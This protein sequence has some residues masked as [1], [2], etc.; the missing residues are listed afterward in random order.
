[1]TDR[2]P[3]HS[4]AA[5]RVL[6]PDVPVVVAD[7]TTAAVLESGGEISVQPAAKLGR[8]MAAARP[9]VC[10][11]PAVA[12]R[13]KV[14]H[15]AAFDVLE[16]FAFVRPAAF[17][18]PT[19]AGLTEALGLPHP[20]TLEDRPL[21]LR[22]VVKT[23]LGELTRYHDIE[24]KPLAE[25]AS[26]MARG[27]WPWGASVLAALGGDPHAATGYGPAAGL[28]VWMRLP[29]WEERPPPP[30]PGSYPIPP[31]D[32]EERLERLLGPGAEARPAQRAYTRAVTAAFQPRPAPEQ[33]LLVLAEAGTG[34]GK[35]LGYVAPASL[36]AERND[37]AVWLSTFTRNLQRQLDQELDRLYPDPDEKKRKV[38]IRKGRENY[39]CILNY[40]D[41]VNRLQTQP[42]DATA[43]GLL[44]RWAGATRNGD[45]VGGDL[46]GWLPE[47]IGREKTL[48]MADRRGECIYAACPHY[49][50]CFIERTV[51][52]ARHANI[53]VANH[54]LV[55]AQAA[56]GGLDDTVRPTRY[57]FDEGHHIFEAADSAFSAQL[58]GMEA[59]DLRRWLLGAEGNAVRTRARGLKRRAEDLIA[60]G[61]NSGASND[62]GL[63]IALDETLTGARALPGQGWRNRVKD[64]VPH[65]PTEIFLGL[66]RKQVLARV[67]SSSPY[68]L[69]A[70]TAPLIEGLADA[71]KDLDTALARLEQP[72]RRLMSGFQRKLDTEA[73]ELDTASR[74]R[75][76]AL[77]RT[78]ERRGAIPA[79]AWRSMLGA[80]GAATPAEF[81]DW[82]SIERMDGQDVDVG[83]HRHWVDPTLPFARALADHTHGM[84][85]TSAT[86]L[87]GEEDEAA[88]WSNAE[89]RVGALHLAPPVVRTAL[90]SPFNY[91]ENT[92]VIVITD[93]RK[94]DLSQVAAAYR[95][96]FLAS[97]G[98]ALGLF[99]AIAR[100]R[101]VHR[102]ISGA[103]DEAGL[104][105]YAQHVDAMDIS[106]L[107]DIFRA[108]EDACLL[109]TDAVREGVD[110]PGRSLRLV[111]FDRVP[112]PRPDIL[113]KARRTAFGKRGYDDAVTRL[114]LKQAF[115]RLIRRDTDRGV[116]VLLDPM[117]PSRLKGA[118]PPDVPY[119]RLGLKDAVAEINAFLK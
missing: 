44:A 35:T 91:I 23:L 8:R 19:V 82:F 70:D 16:L 103:L 102:K 78:L 45:M 85:V 59:A 47:I 108:E 4:P 86:L 101:E 99:T 39:L 43:L 79:A 56:L 41:A 49:Q 96:L 55:M 17:C 112:W 7:W 75:I 6:I 60:A 115:G 64:G 24:V 87:N 31:D 68:S 72:L 83:L 89:Q 74:V 38:V 26:A 67:D 42:G 52:R 118:F 95:E 113:H 111:V 81:V 48:G 25:I 32:S 117:M 107:V 46:P 100:L 80:L 69:E 10:H 36:W 57:V 77:I 106:T 11:R 14:E 15:L 29:E 62:G 9:I 92:K 58:S 22:D 3:L 104:P 34:T 63:V 105:L 12:A 5:R 84:A 109:G 88:D 33:P 53:V 97:G 76:E 18:L 65:G 54:A 37:G 114:R 51:R 94:D 116:F 20:A 73:S 93:V 119:L 50:K 2:P 61:N 30:P 40:E 110:V 1:M 98:G 13:L 27:G 90:V 21:A 66:V 28:R 71:A